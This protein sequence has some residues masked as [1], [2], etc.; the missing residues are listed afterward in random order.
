MVVARVDVRIDQAALR[1]RLRR[2]GG[3][4]DRYLQ[5]LAGRAASRASA[6][7]PGSMGEQITVTPAQQTARALRWQGAGG[8]VFAKLVR[9]PGT[10]AYNFLM[11]ALREVL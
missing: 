11:Q 5:Q 2:P 9:H 1:R 10:R 3:T 7:A 6:L 4:G 8:A